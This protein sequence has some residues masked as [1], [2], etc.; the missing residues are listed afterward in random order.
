[1]DSQENITNI[2]ENLCL[3]WSFNILKLNY[4]H[5]HI[6]EQMFYITL[7]V[8]EQL[9]FYKKYKIASGMQSLYK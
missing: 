7:L 9:S 4:L 5:G 2:W 1:M 6:Y 3:S 8:V